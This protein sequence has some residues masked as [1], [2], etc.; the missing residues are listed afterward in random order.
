MYVSRSSYVNILI[1]LHVKTHGNITS[2]AKI[3]LILVMYNISSLLTTLRHA[4]NDLHCGY[5]LVY[6][7]TKGP[8]NIHWGF[9]PVQKAIGHLLFFAKIIVELQL[10]STSAMIG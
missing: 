10:F 9:G 8:V 2:Y 1:F 4:V 7:P 6:L 5:T 3:N